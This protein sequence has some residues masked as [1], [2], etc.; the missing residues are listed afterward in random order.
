MSTQEF[1]DDVRQFLFPPVELLLRL[2]YASANA[3]AM[4]LGWDTISRVVNERTIDIQRHLSLL[5][6]SG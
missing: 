2:C 3:I 5:P 1:D 4:R 6:V